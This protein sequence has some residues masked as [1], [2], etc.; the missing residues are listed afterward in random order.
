MKE[1]LFR[2]LD[3]QAQAD[4]QAICHVRLY[5]KGTRLFVEGQRAR[6]LFVLCRGRTKVTAATSLGRSLLVRIVK[7]GEVLGMN[8]VILN[9]PYDT[10]AEAIES[11]HAQYITQSD[12]QRFLR[13]HS[14]IF[15][16]VI[17]QL[18]SELRGAY[19]H[20]ICAF[21]ARTARARLAK[22]LL[23]WA[24]SEALPTSNGL[25]FQLGLTHEEISGMIGSSRETVS[26]L[27][28][29]FRDRGFIQTKGKLISV[30]DTNQLK[31]LLP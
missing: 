15:P 7:A 26:R 19:R 25:S 10:T 23:D 13:T 1:G 4:L 31:A 12:F 22:F 27:L 21:T 6:A 2:H 24:Y 20:M 28:S 29:D 3:A 5:R 18:S 30:P 8:A 11:A 14:E 17:E 16:C 9:Q